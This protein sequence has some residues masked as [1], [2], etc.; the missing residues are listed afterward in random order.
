MHQYIFMYWFNNNNVKM[1]FVALKLNGFGI[2]ESELI[3][4]L[5]LALLSQ[6]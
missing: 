1:G 4:R 6:S 2:V 5:A 3:T